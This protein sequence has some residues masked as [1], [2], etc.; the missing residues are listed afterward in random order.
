[1]EI[2]KLESISLGPSF[3]CNFFKH[4]PDIIAFPFYSQSE[5]HEK[6]LKK[7]ICDC[8]WF[9]TYPWEEHEKSSF[10]QFD[11]QGTYSEGK[12]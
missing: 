8:T 10:P 2:L 3:P 11:D 7:Y 5:D 1:M 4:L 9:S 12:N 6:F